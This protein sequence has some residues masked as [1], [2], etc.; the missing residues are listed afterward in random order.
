MS[1]KPIRPL[2]R[3]VDGRSLPGGRLA[4]RLSLDSTR[5][6]ADLDSRY[7]PDH[8]EGWTEVTETLTRSKYALLLTFR[9]SGE[10]VATP[11]WAAVSGDRVYVRT[12]RPSGKV[13]RIRRNPGVLLGSC[14]VRG[15]PLTG[16]ASAVARLLP[17]DEEQ[18]A[19]R[20][21]GDRYGPVRAFCATTQDVLRVDMCYVEL[22]AALPSDGWDRSGAAE[23]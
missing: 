10:R 7:T 2:A 3:P 12:Q 16:V 20:L 22:S 18:V 6:V 17:D 11:V 21:L 8:R 4:D 15:R 19:E 5:I 14:S 1:G 13:A 9:A 23:S